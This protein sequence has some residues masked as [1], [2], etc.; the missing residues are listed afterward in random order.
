MIIKKT[1]LVKG[2]RLGDDWM[3]SANDVQNEITVAKQNATNA[4]NTANTAAQNAID[5][6]K[7]LADIANDNIVTP[8]EKPDTLKEWKQIE[9]ERPKLIAQAGTYSINTDNYNNYYV[10]LANYLTNSGVFLDM[11]VSTNVDGREFKNNFQNYYDV[12]QDLLKAVSD[13]AKAYATGLVDNI[14]IGGRNTYKKSTPIDTLNVDFQREHIDA[15]NGFYAVGRNN[16]DGNNI[17]LWGVIDGNGDWTVSWEMRGTQSVVV[18]L[19]VDIC[20]NGIQYFSSTP[21]NSWKKYSLTVNVNNHSA[22]VYNFVDFS[23]LQWAYYLVRNIKIEKGNKATD[24]T[25]A[26]EDVQEQL[27]NAQNSANVANQKLADIANDNV[28]TASEKPDVMKE[29]QV[30]DAEFPHIRSQALTFSVNYD[31]FSYLYQQLSNYLISIEYANL[32]KDNP[33]NGAEFRQKFVS[34]YTER[35][36]LLKRISDASKNYT[37]STTEAAKTEMAKDALN[38]ALSASYV[39]GNCLFRDVDFRNG[40]NSLGLYNNSGAN[41]NP[42]LINF[43]NIYNAPTKSSQ[44]AVWGFN[45]NNQPTSPGYGG[46]YFNNQSRANAV[47]VMR[48]IMKVPEGVVVEWAA[49]P[50]GDGGHFIW[51][52]PTKGTGKFEEYICIVRCGATG[53]FSGINYVWFNDSGYG[54]RAF[55]VIV[56]YASVF[57]MTDVDRYLED[58]IK[59]NE[60]QT[61]LA[62]AQA[63]N[64][65]NTANR[66]SQ[67]TSF[68]NTTVDG[69]VVA[70][71]SLLVGDV[72]GNNAG[73]TGVTDRGRQSVRMYAGA[74]YANKNTAPFTLQD[75]GLIKMHHPN[76][77]K[78]FELGIVD[79]KLV[80]NVYDDVGNKIMEMGSAGIVFANYIPDSWSTFYLG[81]FNSSS[82]NPYNLNEVS[83]FANGNTKQEMINSPGNIDDPEHWI[84]TIPKSDSEWVNYSQYSAGTSYDS[85]TYKKYEGIYYKGTLQ[86]PQKPNDYTEKLADGWYYYTVST[87][88]WKQ[89]GNPNMNGRYEYAF[90]LFRLSQGQLVE[91]LNY[92]LS[93]IV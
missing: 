36:D 67:L 81:K 1:I 85:N 89:R 76:G 83:S 58:K 78:G 60:Q 40:L 8:Q 50:Y 21:D 52:T 15:P 45:A 75:D 46:F 6:N 2:N 65:Q 44:V 63:D 57:D 88:V 55:E 31:N 71:G 66:V 69:N 16:P 32:T 30:I 73:L 9:A 64:A 23:Q 61:A 70:T 10:A 37:N 18:G 84:V 11:D 91:T 34:Y 19:A 79:G 29:W 13:A 92:E 33:I 5:A 72:V 68:M 59:Q 54:N 62:K 3:P 42:Y 4:Q 51:T 90:T 38:K 93:G 53:I 14:K 77:N 17:R 12:R 80:F 35:T 41:S 7:K 22:D 74:P 87:H 47:F 27:T 86:K 24:W 26:P 49:N 20:D 82:Y 25:P 48:L 39:S 28:L 56:A 43:A